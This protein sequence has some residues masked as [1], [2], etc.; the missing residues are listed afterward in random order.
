VAGALAR[1]RKARHHPDCNC[2]TY[3]RRYCNP[4]DALWSRAMDREL[5]ALTREKP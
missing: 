3:E 2:R 1:A 5:D 4:M